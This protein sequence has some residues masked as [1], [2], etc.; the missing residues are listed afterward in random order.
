M[1]KGG[2]D[3]RV[4]LSRAAGETV[5]VF[6]G[7]AMRLG[8]SLLK[9]ARAAVRANKAKHMMPGGDEFSYD[10][11]ADEAGRAGDEDTHETPPNCSKGNVALSPNLLK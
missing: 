11:R 9:R 6:Q 8:A 4:R 7:P 2:V 3:H 1:V 10:P 5:R